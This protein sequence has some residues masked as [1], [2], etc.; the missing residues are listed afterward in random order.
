PWVEYLSADLSKSVAVTS[1]PLTADAAKLGGSYGMYLR[2]SLG[3]PCY[4]LISDPWTQ[5]ADDPGNGDAR[6]VF[7]AATPDMSSVVFTS[8]RQLLPGAPPDTPAGLAEFNAVY[9][10]T[11][12]GQL[13]L[14]STVAAPRAFA[15]AN[16]QPF[17]FRPGYHVIS[18]DGERIFF[19]T[20]S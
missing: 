10:W 15:G 3:S 9:E 13:R 1:W 5:L 4:R 7:A 17:A 8:S 6:L 12:D 19:T 2:D 16:A 14:V 11:S 18:D 20:S